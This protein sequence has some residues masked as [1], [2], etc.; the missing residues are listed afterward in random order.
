MCLQIVLQLSFR[1]VI[2]FASPI[3]N[4]T[5]H[6]YLILPIITINMVLISKIPT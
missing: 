1:S 5:K 2:S 6:I 3:R 4:H